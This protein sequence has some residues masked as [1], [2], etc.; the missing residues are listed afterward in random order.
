[1]NLTVGLYFSHVKSSLCGVLKA[2]YG[3]MNA[4]IKNKLMNE[5]GRILDTKIEGSQ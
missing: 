1:M 4:C 5:N 2:F 3:N